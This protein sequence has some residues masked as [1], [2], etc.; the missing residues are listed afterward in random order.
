MG[1]ASSCSWSAPDGE[2]K[3]KKSKVRR[4]GWGAVLLGGDG[5]LVRV[6]GDGDRLGWGRRVAEGR[7]EW[8]RGLAGRAM[9]RVR[10]LTPVRTGRLARGWSGGGSAAL[11]VGEGGGESGSIRVEESREVTAVE[12][13]NRVPYVG[14]VEYGTRRMAARAMVRRALREVK[15]QK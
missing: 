11:S 7:S 4:R 5:M 3:R 10:A 15:R 9:G 12:V 13:E 6:E 2:V 1:C 8:V 14:F